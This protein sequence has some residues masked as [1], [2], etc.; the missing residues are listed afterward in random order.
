[1]VS[2][3]IIRCPF[4]RPAPRD[5]DEMMVAIFESIDRMLNIVRPRKI[6]YMAIDGTVSILS[7]CFNSLRVFLL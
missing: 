7:T 5:E 1:M 4:C 6:L 3:L 2:L